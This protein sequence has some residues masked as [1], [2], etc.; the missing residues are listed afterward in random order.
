MSEDADGIRVV[1]VPERERF[2]LRDGDHLIGLATYAVVPADD[3][4]G[5]ERVVFFHTEVA[6]AREGQGLAGRLAAAALDSAV[7]A[8]RVIVPVCPYVTAYL[9]RHPEPYAG[10]V[11]APTPADLRAADEAARRAGA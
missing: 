1:D 7:A 5:G 4:G 10:H 2:E 8:G 11:A 6:E 3:T 9:E